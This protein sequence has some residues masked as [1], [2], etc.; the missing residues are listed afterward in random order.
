MGIRRGKII[1]YEGH[2]RSNVNVIILAY[3]VLLTIKVIYQWK[4]QPLDI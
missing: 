2:F 3:S 4:R 1:V